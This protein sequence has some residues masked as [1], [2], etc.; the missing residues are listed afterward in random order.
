MNIKPLPVDFNNGIAIGSNIRSINISFT[1]MLT[2]K[3]LQ[4]VPK[5]YRTEI[6]DILLTALLLAIGD[7]KGTYD[8]CLMLEGHGRE[9]IIKHI[10]LSR[11]IGWF[12]TIF[13]VCL[14]IED[15]NNVGN[16]IKIVKET[17]RRF[18]SKGIGYGIISYLN[19]NIS[20]IQYKLKFQLPWP[21]GK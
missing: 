19:S 9:D 7:W 2:K 11:T 13:P 10:N 20:D 12:T 15:G 16:A 4:Q 6:N 3:L 17:L 18:R 5:V 14:R 21:V 8:L 1:E